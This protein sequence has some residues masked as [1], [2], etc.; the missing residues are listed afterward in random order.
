MLATCGDLLC[1]RVAGVLERF[2]REDCGGAIEA[3][4]ALVDFSGL[5]LTGVSERWGE[6]R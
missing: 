4:V 3:R 2:A 6:G 1:E 5:G